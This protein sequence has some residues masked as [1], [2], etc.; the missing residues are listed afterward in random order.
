MTIKN[1]AERA[2]LK[3]IGAIVADAL[4]TMGAAIRPGM[5]TAELDAIGEEVLLSRGARSAPQLCYNFPGATCISVNNQVAHGIPGAYV[6]KA[7]DLVNIDVSAEK[8][9]FFGDNGSSFAVGEVSPERQR[10]LREGRKVLNK[11]IAQVKHGQPLN[12]IGKT[13]EKEARKRGYT[14]IRNLGSH[15]VGRSLHEEPSFIAPYND[16]AEHRMLR[17]GMVITI[18]PFLSTGATQVLQDADGWTL[19]TP[20][21]FDTVQ[22]EHSMIVTKGKPVILT[23]AT[24]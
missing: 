12:I 9:G 24:A 13:L 6:L 8:D 15:G 18:E 10:L 16:P 19:Y 2:A 17:E 1:A 21:N 14:L 23:Q 5:T 11:A 22:F 3:A 20:K 4:K 7:G